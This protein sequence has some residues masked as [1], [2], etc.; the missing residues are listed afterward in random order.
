MSEAGRINP[1]LK[2]RFGCNDYGQPIFRIVW[3]DA[4]TE[5]RF[6]IFNEFSGPIFLREIRGLKEVPKYSY[7]KSVW[8]LERWLPP[9]KCYTDEIPATKEGS[10]EPLFA[11]MD[12][13]HKPV[14][15]VEDQ[16]MRIIQAALNPTKLPGDRKSD[17][18]KQEQMEFDYEVEQIK[19]ELTEAGR[20]WVGHR[21]HSGEGIIKP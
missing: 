15:I 6:G 10:Y 7:L 16:V 12:D 8:V 19:E 11:F 17:L 9:E 4:Q 1:I 21:L 13:N 20:T 3:S 18:K 14:P 5:K 2:G